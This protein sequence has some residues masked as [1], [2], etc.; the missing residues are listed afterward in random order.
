MGLGL[1]E[2]RRTLQA[3]LS[4]FGAI[5]IG[6]Y[7][8]QAEVSRAAF[9]TTLPI[10]VA[11]VLVGRWIARQQ[12][13]RQRAAGGAMSPT[14][15]VGKGAAVRQV[16]SELQRNTDAGYLPCAVCIL[17]DDSDEVMANGNSLPRVPYHGLVSSCDQ[18]SL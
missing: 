18:W 15:I 2:Y 14:L 6:S 9:V 10:G 7:W 16:A 5:A 3:S 8:L 1:G 12:L 11:A 4:V 13:V 17:D